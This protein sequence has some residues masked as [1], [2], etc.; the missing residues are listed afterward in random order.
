MITSFQDLA[1]SSAREMLGLTHKGPGH[2]APTKED[3]IADRQKSAFK[4]QPENKDKFIT[5]GLWSWSR[6][7]NYFGEIV[8][9]FGVT[10][11]A[12]PVLQGWQWVTLISPIFIVILLTKISGVNLLEARADE[13]W[14]GQKDY[15]TYKAKTPVLIPKPPSKQIKEQD[16]AKTQ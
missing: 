4:A 5:S 3:R 16:Y 15:E 13:K 8:L 1:I 9:W 2:R 12:L 7:P 6:H 14:G 11:I 10:I